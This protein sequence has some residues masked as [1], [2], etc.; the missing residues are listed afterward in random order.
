MIEWSPF[1]SCAHISYLRSY[2]RSDNWQD[3]ARGRGEKFEIKI[4]IVRAQEQSQHKSTRKAGKCFREIIFQ[5]IIIIFLIFVLNHI[6]IYID[7]GMSIR[8][9]IYIY[10]KINL[11][12]WVVWI[13]ISEFLWSGNLCSRISNLKNHL[14]FWKRK[15]IL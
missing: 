6:N 12:V 13:V 11:K 10:I 1:N 14:W 15:I 9:H 3:R 8:Y 4:F 7:M 5:K 2:N